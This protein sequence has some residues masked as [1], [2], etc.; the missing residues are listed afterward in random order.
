VAKELRSLH[1][2]LPEARS[3]L[4][5]ADSVLA[6][7]T[8]SAVVLPMASFCLGGVVVADISWSKRVGHAH[9]VTLESTAMLRRVHE[10]EMDPDET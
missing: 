6:R 5:S 8:F 1:Q 4:L 2:S 10:S 3:R 9:E 7:F